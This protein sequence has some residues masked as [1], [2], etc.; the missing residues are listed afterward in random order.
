MIRLVL[1]LRQNVL[2]YKEH[3]WGKFLSEVS[4]CSFFGWVK[5]SRSLQGRLSQSIVKLRGLMASVQVL[6]A[7]SFIVQFTLYTKLSAFNR[8]SAVMST[9]ERLEVGKGF[10]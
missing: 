9:S 1:S 7:Q 4:A 2:V 6:A 5:I 3:L 8:R 10:V